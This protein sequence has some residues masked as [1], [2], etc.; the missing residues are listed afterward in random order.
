[1]SY[2]VSRQIRD[3]AIALLAALTAPVSV[4][5]GAFRPLAAEQLP[6]LPNLGDETLD[7]DET[8]LP[9]STLRRCGR[10]ELGHMPLREGGAPLGPVDCSLPRASGRRRPNRAHLH[11]EAINGHQRPS[12][13]IKASSRSSARSRNG[14]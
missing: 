13:A 11:S 12:T 3:A 14:R 9:C 8:P 5:A 7:G 10:L 2:H 1:M 6:G 4:V